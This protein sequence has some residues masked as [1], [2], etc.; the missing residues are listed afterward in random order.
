MSETQT[1][2]IRETRELKVY[3]KVHT[4]YCVEPST[5]QYKEILENFSEESGTGSDE[6]EQLLLTYTPT[7]IKT[8]PLKHCYTVLTFSSLINDENTT[9]FKVF[10]CWPGS[11]TDNLSIQMLLRIAL[12]SSDLIMLMFCFKY[13]SV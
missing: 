12:L 7:Y 5:V 8:F 4:A 10:K 9:E 1:D 3:R 6:A 11:L 2:Q 13:F